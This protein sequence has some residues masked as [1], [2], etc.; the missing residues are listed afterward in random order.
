[1]TSS[2]VLAGSGLVFALAAGWPTVVGRLDV[3]AA[4]C[5]SA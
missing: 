1:M 3:P 4:C 5:T 2:P